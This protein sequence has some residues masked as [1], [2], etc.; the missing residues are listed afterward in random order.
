MILTAL[1]CL[2]G[3]GAVIGSGILAYKCYKAFQAKDSYSSFEALS[4]GI[5]AALYAPIGI[6]IA[7]MPGI[8][9]GA[10]VFYGVLQG[11]TDNLLGT[12]AFYAGSNSFK[13]AYLRMIL[14]APVFSMVDENTK[15]SVQEFFIERLSE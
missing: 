13:G 4:F 1:R 15:I 2:T 12:L 14:D 11:L 7:T 8:G 3:I 10:L 9:W 5:R 6:L